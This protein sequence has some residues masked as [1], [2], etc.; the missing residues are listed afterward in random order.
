MR[1]NL[2]LQNIRHSLPRTIVSLAGIGIAI[3]LIFVQLGFRGAV[4]NTALMIYEKMDFDLVVRSRDYLHFIDSGNIPQTALDAAR[5]VNGVQSAVPFHV[6][7]VNWRN[8]LNSDLRGMVLMGVEPA[9]PTFNSLEV[10]RDL[11]KLTSFSQVLV[12]SESSPEFGPADGHEFSVADIGVQTELAGQK[13]R[14]AGLYRMGAGLTANGSAIISVDGYNRLVPWDSVQRPAMGLIKVEPGFNLNEVAAQIIQLNSDAQHQPLVEVLTRQQVLN[15]EINRWIGETPIGFVFTLGV[16]TA[17]IVGAAI[18]YMVLSNDVATRLKEY[19]TLRAMGYRNSWLA[20]VVLKQAIW[21]A[22]FAFVPSVIVSI[23]FYEIT[24]ILANLPIF[25]TTS[26]LVFVF[27]LTQLMCMI[28]G[29]LALRKLWSAE[30][31]SLF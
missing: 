1:V 14:I 24:S 31:A 21:L 26:R 19:A 20:A 4:E 10:S 27:M 7:L 8:P 12:D 16:G 11:E 15:R 17:F 13:V 30:P 5:S 29:T 25:M 23:A 2:A 9:L 28:S 18:F 6:T 3:T 22:L